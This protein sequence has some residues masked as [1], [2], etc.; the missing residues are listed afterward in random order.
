MVPFDWRLSLPSPF[1]SSHKHSQ[2]SLS[3]YLKSACVTSIKYLW[4]GD[5]KY[6][7][8]VPYCFEWRNIILRKTE[9]FG[10]L[11]PS[12]LRHFM[13]PPMHNF[14]CS[15]RPLISSRRFWEAGSV[16]KWGMLR[17]WITAQ[18]QANQC[19]QLYGG[20]HIKSW[21]TLKNSSLWVWGSVP[22]TTTYIMGVPGPKRPGNNR[23]E[24][25]SAVQDLMC[26]PPYRS[27]RDFGAHRFRL[28]CRF[29]CVYL[30]IEE[31]RSSWTKYVIY[32]QCRLWLART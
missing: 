2:I 22:Q 30:M 26:R 3:S 5:P 25:F 31:I 9:W 19:R 15:L 24:D 4:M 1:L 17:L 32:V 14:P 27:L 8:D 16:R 6:F 10:W 29:I 13:Y 12:P 11:P 20:R 21:T 23:L 18:S 7:E 28:A